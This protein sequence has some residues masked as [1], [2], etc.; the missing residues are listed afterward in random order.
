MIGKGNWNQA[1]IIYWRPPAVLSLTYGV[2]PFASMRRP[3]RHVEECGFNF[4]KGKW[5]PVYRDK[6]IHSHTD[7]QLSR[8]HDCGKIRWGLVRQ[9]WP[10]C[11]MIRSEWVNYG[12]HNRSR[13]RASERTNIP[14][15]RDRKRFCAHP[16]QHVSER[17]HLPPISYAFHRD[18]EQTLALVDCASTEDEIWLL[19]NV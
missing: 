19:G 18:R 10:R 2:P 17:R 11:R 14:S 8:R 15:V 16:C 6:H 7:T 4:A 1:V 3:S 13:L 5:P 12:A 9:L